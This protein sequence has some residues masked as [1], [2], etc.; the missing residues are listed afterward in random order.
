M[1]PSP[2]TVLVVG[3]PARTSAILIALTDAATALGDTT[4]DELAGTLARGAPDVLVVVGGDAELAAVGAVLPDAPAT[5]ALAVLDEAIEPGHLVAAGIGAVVSA[6]ADAA[7]LAEAVSG[8]FHGEGFLDAALARHVLDAHRA[9][10]P[11][12]LSATED[13]VLSRLAEGT[14]VATL[15]DDYAV[16]PRLVRLHA[17]G[18]LARLL[19]A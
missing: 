2:P 17:G 9:A 13:E 12:A 15:A 4:A 18:A 19:P 16:T 6:G 8:L 3:P 7:M 11:D 10:G 5:R 14:D 1:E